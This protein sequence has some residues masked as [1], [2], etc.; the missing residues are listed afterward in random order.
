MRKPK[1]TPLQEKFVNNLLEGMH[2]D[3]AYIK[4]GYKAKGAAARTNA[5]RLLTNANV[6]AILDKRQKRASDKAEITQQR[7]LEEESRLAFYD[8]KELFDENGKIRP[9][10]QLPENIRRAIHGFEIIYTKLGDIKYKYK[11]A[12]KGKSLNRLERIEGMFSPEKHELVGDAF[13]AIV[14]DAIANRA[15]KK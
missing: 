10:H 7:T 14:A 13:A 15:K 5:S 12:D 4:A 1:L 9:I 8:P 11:F 3:Q 2:Q 6:R